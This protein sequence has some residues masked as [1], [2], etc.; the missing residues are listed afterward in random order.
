VFYSRETILVSACS[1]NTCIGVFTAI[2]EIYLTDIIFLKN[3]YF[4]PRRLLHLHNGVAEHE[5]SS[6]LMRLQQINLMQL[7]RSPQRVRGARGAAE[8]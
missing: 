8:N 5:C 6:W 4:T 3:S 7:P 1:K 2:F